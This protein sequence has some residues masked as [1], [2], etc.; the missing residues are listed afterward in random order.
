MEVRAVERGRK[1]FLYAS[2]RHPSPTGLKFLPPSLLRHPNRNGA[3]KFDLIR[4][5][6]PF[7]SLRDPFEAPAIEYLKR[8]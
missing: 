2:F 1:M 6:I 3:F 7:K 4:F 8:E 5:I